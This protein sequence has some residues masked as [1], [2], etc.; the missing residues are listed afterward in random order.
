M[1]ISYSC[2]QIIS[3][4][5]KEH[6]SKVTSTQY[7]QLTLCNCQVNEENPMDG[8]CQTMDAVYD[9]PVTPPESPKIVICVG[10]GTWKKR[11]YDHKT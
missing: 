7:N 1:K 6:N 11:Y 2:I 3:K 10:I 5:Y 9:C 4:T 8:K